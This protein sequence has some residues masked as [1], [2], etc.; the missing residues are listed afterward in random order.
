[1]NKDKLIEQYGFIFEEA[2]ID[3][4]NKVGKYVKVSAHHEIIDIGS[5][6][7]HIPLLLS[8]AIKI[9]REDEGGDELLLYFIEKGDSCALSFSCALEGKKSDV[10]AITESDSEILMIPISY[11]EQWMANYRS[12]RNFVIDSY[13]TRTRELLE[14]VDTIAFL[15]MDQRILKHLQDKAKVI[16][17][18]VIIT[19]HEQISN[20]LHTSR[21]VVS[22]ILK[23][24]ENEGKIKL[25]RNEIKVIDL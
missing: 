19:T 13:Q 16:G 20:D 18:D 10:R 12:W 4:M 1:M 24:L 2:L 21:V 6:L 11:M 8:G 22:R 7:S 23:K 15:K 3:K 5:E 9:L 25:F 17:N 14:T